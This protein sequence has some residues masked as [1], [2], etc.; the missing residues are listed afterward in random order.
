MHDAMAYDVALSFAG[1]QRDYV[2]QVAQCLRDAGVEVFFDDFE[3]P[4][5]WGHDLAVHFDRVY[6]TGARFVVP[7]VSRQYASR[8]WPQ[9]E[10]RSALAA[11][12]QA[13]EPFLLPVRFDDTELPGLRP[14]I[15]YLDGL[16]LTPEQVAA[17]VLQRLGRQA[18]PAAR[19]SD[20]ADYR[21]PTLPPANFN[22]Y[23]EAE[24]VFA[25]LRESLTKRAKDLEGRGFGVHAQ[26]R[27]GRYVLRIMRSGQ[28]VYGL[29]V[30]IGGD[31]GDNTMCFSTGSGGHISPGSTNAHGTVEWDKDRGAPVVKVFNLSLLHDMGH[32]Y[33]LTAKELADATT[34]RVP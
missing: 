1:E 26:E 27:N 3:T 16:S 14:T 17:A 19:S 22:P 11:A 10:F 30:W 2:R 12:V 5:L 25:H 33:R 7:F 29:D 31:W 20:L 24:G 4:E 34:R 13:R 8:A 23:A 28:T 21:L 32:E 9:H 18:N 6:R 15:H